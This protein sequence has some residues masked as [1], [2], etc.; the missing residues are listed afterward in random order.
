[1]LE[2]KHTIYQLLFHNYSCKKYKKNIWK[3]LNLANYSWTRSFVFEFIYTRRPNKPY[4]RECSI[5]VGPLR[6]SHRGRLF[7]AD[8]SVARSSFSGGEGVDNTAKASAFRPTITKT[9][10]VNANPPELVTTGQSIN[11]GT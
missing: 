1:M 9:A 4:V 2:M 6:L 8:S 7:H 11:S 5:F 10:P 3:D